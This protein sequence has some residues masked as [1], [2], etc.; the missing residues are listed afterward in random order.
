MN[1][2]KHWY[3]PVPTFDTDINDPDF[4]EKNAE[5]WR[6][7]KV[8]WD[9]QAKRYRDITILCGVSIALIVVGMLLL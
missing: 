4:W 7:Q 8:F 9:K 2:L 1:P 5:F 6:A 3:N